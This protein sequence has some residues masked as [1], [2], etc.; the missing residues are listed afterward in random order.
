MISAHYF[1]GQT[2]RMFPVSLSL[3]VDNITLNNEAF[4]K[5]YA[6]ADT[7]LAEPYGFAPLVLDFADGARCEIP[8]GGDHSAV[9]DALSYRPSRVEWMQEHWIGA[10]AALVA[11]IALGIAAYQWGIPFAGEKLA[12]LV[13]AEMDKVIGEKAVKAIDGNELKP[14]RLSE[15]RVAEVQAIFD[16]IKP[17]NSPQHLRLLVREVSPFI[18]PNAFA[19]P[20]GTIVLTDA[21]VLLALGKNA[22]FD[23]T[24]TAK[25]AGIF[26]HEFGHIQYRHTIKAMARSSITVALS[27]ALF[28]D[29]SAVVSTTPALVLQ[30]K[31]SQ[32][33]EEE[34]DR[35]A[36]ATLN[37]RG[38]STW[39]LASL[40]EHFTEKEK[41][42]MDK[43]PR[44]LTFTMGYVAT[45]PVTE[46]RIMKFRAA[47]PAPR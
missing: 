24:S 45:H 1:D 20:D 22:S 4:N 17:A 16:Q 27:A 13:P 12:T 18:G 10:L 37:N 25:L 8:V 2:A 33:M 3:G 36:I 40:F 7:K 34:A 30:A 26:A 41:Q 19:F 5:T 23:N 29:F 14:T 43:M 46:G 15:Q 31:H 38:I 28:G 21:M 35:Y 44:W 9:F 47:S 42:D 32:A 39:P 6:K 11:L